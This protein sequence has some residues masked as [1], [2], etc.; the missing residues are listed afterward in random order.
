[1]E[2]RRARRQRKLEPIKIAEDHV[3]ITEEL[4]GTGGFSE[5]YLADYN[6]RNAADKALCFLNGS[7]R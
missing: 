2:A 4:L 3:A 5:V 7:R 6:G 1:M